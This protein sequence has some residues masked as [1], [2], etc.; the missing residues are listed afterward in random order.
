MSKH[1]KYASSRDGRYVSD[2]ANTNGIVSQEFLADGKDSI[3]WVTGVNPKVL[4]EWADLIE[5]CYGHLEHGSVDIGLV[6]PYEDT[7]K[8]PALI[9]GHAEDDRWIMASPRVDCEVGPRERDPETLL[10]GCGDE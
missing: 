10:P 9:A 2:I 6:E 5:F 4:R 8:A 1:T 7:D 3:E